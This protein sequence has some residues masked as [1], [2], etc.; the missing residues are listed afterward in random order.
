MKTKI[1]L[2]SVS[3]GVV[4]WATAA[5]ASNSPKMDAEIIGLA[6]HWAT[7]KYLTK[8]DSAVQTKMAEVSREADALVSRY[9]EHVE[10]LIWQGIIT[11][12][13]ASLT[14]GFSALDLAT[15]ARDILARAEKMDPKA[16][17]AGA[18]TSLGVLY[19]RVPGFPIGWGNVDK[20]RRYLEEAVA[21]APNGRDAHYFYADFLYSQGEY[22]KAQKVL[23]RGLHLPEHPE[24]PL[25]NK[26]FPIVMHQ[27]LDKIRDRM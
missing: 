2:W 25:W 10:P 19:Y 14:W 17:D 23:L 5:A 20:A 12:E 26:N 18:P 4:M 11:S 8:S 1:A 16:L 27:L 15:K 7:V 22:R 13:R 3:I 21:N 24:R 9:P 6:R